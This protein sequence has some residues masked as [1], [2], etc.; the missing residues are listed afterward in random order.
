MTRP[1]VTITVSGITGS[2]KSKVLAAIERL[3]M[4]EF[5]ITTISSPALAAERR[6]A[7]P[8][9]VP[10]LAEIQNLSNYDWL[11]TEHNVPREA[12][13]QP[14]SDTDGNSMYSAL[15]AAIQNKNGLHLLHDYGE[16]MQCMHCYGIDDGSGTSDLPTDCPGVKLTREQHAA[17]IRN[18]QDYTNEQGWHPVSKIGK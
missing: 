3:L 10:T 4:Q 16:G 14:A 18:T 15:E 2:G 8:D 5:R 13:P 7:N 9:A 6:L 11:L 1:I 12:Q 17:V